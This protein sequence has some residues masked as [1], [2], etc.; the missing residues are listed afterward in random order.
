MYLRHALT[1]TAAVVL[2]SAVAFAQSTLPAFPQA[3]TQTG[4]EERDTPISLVGC[5]QREADYRRANDSGRG[6]VAGTGLGRGNEYVLIN[7]SRVDASSTTQTASA[8]CSPDR[9][10]QAYE[11]TGNRERELEPFVGRVVHI[12]GMLKEAD[13]A[14]VGTTGAASNPSGGFDPLGQDLKLFEVELTSFQAVAAAAPSQTA[15]PAPVTEP[16]GTARAQAR[17]EQ[18]DELPRTAGPLPIAGL[19]A[20]LSLGGAFG[21][22]AMRRR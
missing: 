12:T 6:G 18:V 3:A 4:V 5:V 7:A 22:R 13:T 17:V 20:L 8:G 16:I 10:A 1:L 19:L 11:L 9:T 21:I 14:T 15:A 2:S